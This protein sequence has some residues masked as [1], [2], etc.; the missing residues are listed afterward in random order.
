MFGS[1]FFLLKHSFGRKGS[2]MY[3][4]YPVRRRSIL[5]DGCDINLLR[6]CGFRI[7]DG[8]S[9]SEILKRAIEREASE[10]DETVSCAETGLSPRD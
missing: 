2:I 3:R 4:Q 6:S 8:S 10:Q 9:I 1:L 5:R 7:P